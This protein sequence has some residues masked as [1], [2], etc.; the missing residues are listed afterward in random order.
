MNS[1][2]GSRLVLRDLPL[3]VRLVLALFLVSVGT[4]YAAALVQ[5][6]FQQARPGHLLPDSEDIVRTFSGVQG[7]PQSKIEQLITADETR[8]FNGQGTMRPAFTTKSS[9]WK[10][11]IKATAKELKTKDLAKAETQLRQERDAEAAAL[12]AWIH[13]GAA[14]QDYE[15]DHFPLPPEL[16]SAPITSKPQRSPQLLPSALSRGA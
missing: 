2:P 1:T 10:S 7:Q 4:G 8:P 9:G 5:I 14:Q 13:A 3:P 6:H 15:K 16:A 12:L 11:A